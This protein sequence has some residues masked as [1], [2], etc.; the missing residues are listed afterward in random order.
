[1]RPRR[2]RHV[3]P[4]ALPGIKGY[5]I[6]FAGNTLTA[7]SHLEPWP[8]RP[9][10]TRIPSASSRTEGPTAPDA[11]SGISGG[12]GEQLQAAVL[13]RTAGEPGLM[14]TSTSEVGALVPR[15][16]TAQ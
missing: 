6:S 10:G 3:F 16:R 15:K 11:D 5:A 4:L 14:S 13:A 1:M 9:R 8:A 12:I 7:G 2:V